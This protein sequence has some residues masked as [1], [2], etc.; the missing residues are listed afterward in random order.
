MG[1]VDIVHNSSVGNFR[2]KFL[3]QGNCKAHLP[4]NSS[5]FLAN[6]FAIA[7]LLKNPH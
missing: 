2:K 6:Q 4:Y 3:R 5:I 7:S 1:I